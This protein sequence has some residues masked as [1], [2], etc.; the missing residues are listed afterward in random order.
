[1]PHFYTIGAPKVT[2][3]PSSQR[4]EV[5]DNVMLI[6]T[7]SGIGIE[8]FIYQW[9]R[10]DYSI[11]GG[12]KPV[13]FIYNVPKRSS[14]YHTYSCVVWDVVGNSAVSNSVKLFVSSKYICVLLSITDTVVSY[15]DNTVWCKILMRE[16]IDEFDKF[17]TIHQY[18][19]YQNFYI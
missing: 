4:V 14:K 9:Y 13:L 7:P 17:P 16:N 2:V 12:N 8:N 1:M 11:K 3:T 10:R 19:P 5:T 15:V 6:A 18:F